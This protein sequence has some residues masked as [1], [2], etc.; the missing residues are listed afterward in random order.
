MPAA[1]LHGAGGDDPATFPAADDD[2]RVSLVLHWWRREAQEGVGIDAHE[3][4]FGANLLRHLHQNIEDDA[5]RK[6]L[7]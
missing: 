7:L 6:T 5:S 1:P 3:G 4:A 2:D